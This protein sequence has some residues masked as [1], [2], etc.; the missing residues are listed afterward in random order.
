M[1]EYRKVVPF[2]EEDEVMY[3]HIK[4]SVNFIREFNY[5]K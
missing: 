2:I 5:K 1:G 3:T 4:N